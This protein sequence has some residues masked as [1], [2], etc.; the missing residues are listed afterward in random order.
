MKR[1]I[2]L[3]LVLAL[4]IGLTAC[5]SMTGNKEIP[6]EKI[7]SEALAYLNS[8]YSDTFT[9]NVYTPSSWAYEYESITFG[10]EKFPGVVVEVRVYKNDDGT[11]RFKDNYYHCYMLE[12]AVS[13]CRNILDLESAAV[14]IRFP[15][16]I[17][18]DELGD[19]KSFEEWVKLGTCNME[20]FV[21]TKNTLSDDIQAG[22]V[23]SVAAEKIIGSVTFMTTN[24]GNLLADRELDEILN[25]QRE[26]VVRQNK[27][28]INSDF[29]ISTL[30]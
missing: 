9:A 1:V 16:T 20:I 7:C 18:S 2:P 8:N 27:Y 13:Y 10:S 6:A 23:N 5:G 11:Y 29:E 12:E 15:H 19:A 26:F 28:F 22:L 4:A 30:R 17:W 21:I 14:K 25:N 3:F 24:D